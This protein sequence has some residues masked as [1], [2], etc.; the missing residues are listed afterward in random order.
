VS[1]DE[2]EPS[3]HSNAGSRLVA[4][5]ISSTLGRAFV[6]ARADHAREDERPSMK[7]SF[8]ILPSLITFLG[9]TLLGCNVTR[10]PIDEDA[11]D[12]GSVVR[13][14]WRPSGP[15]VPPAVWED[16]IDAGSAAYMPVRVAR[17]EFE[18]GVHQPWE[19][20]T[21]SVSTLRVRVVPGEMIVTDRYGEERVVPVRVLVTDEYGHTLVK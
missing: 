8:Y 10:P 5:E 11:I 15:P 3:F 18:T 21:P 16:S 14:N 7:P 9:I 17:P 2:L 12:N 1:C 6:H 4:A 20:W 19:N 13:S